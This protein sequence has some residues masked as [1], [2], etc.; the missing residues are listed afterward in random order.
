MRQIQ[1]ILLIAAIGLI[2]AAPWLHRVYLIQ[3]IY[4]S[5]EARNAVLESTLS[6]QENYGLL[7]STL[8]LKNVQIQDGSVISV[9]D[10]QYPAPAKRCAE[11]EITVTYELTSKNITATVPFNEQNIC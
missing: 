8:H 2:L 7:L 1:I 5:P 9:Y 10:F 4:A 3:E 11:H 6:L